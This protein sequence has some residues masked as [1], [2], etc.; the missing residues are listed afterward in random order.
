MKTGAATG[1]RLAPIKHVGA[2]PECDLLIIRGRDAPQ[3]LRPRP[4][5]G[6]TLGAD[7][8]RLPCVAVRHPLPFAADYHYREGTRTP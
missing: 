6:S 8:R 3:S 4:V 2:L 1:L 7:G 5:P